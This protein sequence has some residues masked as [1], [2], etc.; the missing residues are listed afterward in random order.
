MD[1]SGRYLMEW[2]DNQPSTGLAAATTVTAPISRSISM[3]RD[4][5]TLTGQVTDAPGDGALADAWVFAINS[6]GATT[7]GVT[8][9]NGG[10]QIRNLATGTYRVA[11]INPFTGEVE[12][13]QDAPDYA[14]G[15]PVAITSV[16]TTTVSPNL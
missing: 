3:V 4:F 1:S 11:V 2:Y 16:A 10:Y 15:T 13:W 6:H 7:G 9:G 12:F 14:G 5:G 8:V